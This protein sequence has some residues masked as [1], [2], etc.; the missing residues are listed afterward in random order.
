MQIEKACFPGELAYSREHMR[1]LL[2]SRNSAT[3]VEEDGRGVRG[4]VTAVFEPG[5]GVAGIETIGVSPDARGEGVGKRL[6]SAAESL[7]ASRGVKVSRLEVSTGNAA[8]ISLYSKAGYT[9]KCEIPDYYIYEHD[10]TRDAYLMEK[11]V[12]SGRTARAP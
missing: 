1:E 4:Y 8:A 12:S 7:M 3:F 10:G 9:V 11:G 5:T 2:S 6:L